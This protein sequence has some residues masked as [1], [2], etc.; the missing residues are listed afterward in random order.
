MQ[1][2]TEPEELQVLRNLEVALDMEMHME[3][4]DKALPEVMPVVVKAVVDM[5]KVAVAKYREKELLRVATLQEEVV[6]EN[7]K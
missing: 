3:E 1:E 5:V 2:A 4:E 7:A 6:A